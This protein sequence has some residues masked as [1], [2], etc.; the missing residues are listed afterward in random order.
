MTF[1]RSTALFFSLCL[2]W[3]ICIVSFLFFVTSKSKIDPLSSHELHILCWGDYFHNDTLHDFEKKSGIR[4]HLHTYA[5]T[6]ELI[7]KI[8]STGTGD[9]DLIFT[10]DDAMRILAEEG[11]IA[12]LPQNLSLP[13]L[14]PIMTL[15]FD[16][17]GKMVLP[18]TWEAM[19]IA[20]TV[21]DKIDVTEDNA[22]ALL[23]EGPCTLQIGMTSDLIEAIDLASL[24]LHGKKESLTQEELKEVRDLLIFQKTKTS[25]YS[26]HRAMTM[27]ANGS[28]NFSTLRSSYYIQ[29]I[30]ENETEKT[31][32]K[33]VIP[34]QGVFIS[35]EGVALTK[36]T[37][38][39]DKIALFL[40]YI[41]QPRVMAMQISC[42]PLF[43]SVR[44]SYSFLPKGD[45]IDRFAQEHLNAPEKYLFDHLI[46][47]EQSTLT[48]VEIKGA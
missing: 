14:V 45:L 7:S 22:L 17:E 5:S 43:A 2:G 19:G 28:A 27:L 20:T 26:D 36:T 39:H 23:F 35:V 29:M 13:P 15:P 3:S 30:T 42:C 9:Y 48:W 32:L 21:H 6:T 8:R 12:F 44:E 46:P 10:S 33:Y 16:P 37:S 34:K 47:H 1:F 25:A 18:Y 38:N 11:Y 31:N 41:Y 40:E 24:Y 4:I